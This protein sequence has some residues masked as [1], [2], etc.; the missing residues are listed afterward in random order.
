MPEFKP[1]SPFLWYHI[2]LTNLMLYILLRKCNLELYMAAT[3]VTEVTERGVG[4]TEKASLCS[5][6]QKVT[7][8]RYGLV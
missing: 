3:E 8:N 1:R 7:K 2:A 4:G 6:W 5:L